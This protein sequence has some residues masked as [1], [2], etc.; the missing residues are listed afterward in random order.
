M[1]S[2]RLLADANIPFAD[3][4]FSGIGSVRTLPGRAITQ[5]DLMDVE[6]LL[7]RSVTPVTAE[8]LRGTPVR[9]VGTA[10][11]GTDHIDIAGLA[12]AGISVAAAPGSNAESVVEYVLAALLLL[13]VEQEGGLRGKTLGV[14]GCGHVGGRLAR[15]A[16]ALGL[17]V[18]RCDPPLAEAA[19]AR[20]EA[21]G[22]VPLAAV[23]AEADIL[24]L[25]TPL[26][27]RAE[28]R[29]PTHHLIGAAELVQM[30]RGAW[31][32]NAA[33]G[34][35]V[36]N[37]ALV[38][39]LATDRIGAAVMDVWE[40][41][42]LPDLALIRQV[43]LAT[44]HIAGYSFDGKVE[45]TRMLEVALRAWLEAEGETPPLAWDAEAVLAPDAPLIVEAASGP[46]PLSPQAETAWLHHLARQAYDLRADDQR[47]RAAVLEGSPNERA[48]AFQHL[49]KT[50]PPRR[51]WSRFAVQGGVL[52][53]LRQAVTEGLGM[54]WMNDRV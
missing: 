44:P 17:R 8:G 41:E 36:D 33:R 6:V 47:F 24:T 18:L 21:H 7:V 38:E 19:E 14:V 32:I 16:E 20:D 48:A 29:H 31:L 4:A 15:R 35:V 2:L 45:G 28:S 10:T 12:A 54:R 27:S 50:Y 42:P 52:Q 30:K 43:A 3:A 39:A 11:A 25:H 34:A 51:A 49:R 23:L 46:G 40:G 53:A 13:A 1:S 26:T 22:F 9:F 37:R 5:N